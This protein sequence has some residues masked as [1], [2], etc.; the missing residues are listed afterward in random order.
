MTS[1]NRLPITG[2]KPKDLV[3]IPWRVAFALQADG[4]Y[5]RSDIIW[6]KPN[7]MPSSVKD[8]PTT[9]HEYVFLLSKSA[10][11]HYDGQA[12]AEP[13][14]ESTLREI[15]EGYNGQATKDYESAGVQDP[16]SVKARIIA[17]KRGKN[18][19][20]GD[21]RKDG[22]NERWDSSTPALTRNRRTV[23][24]IPTQPFKGAHFATFPEALVE[25]CILAGCPEGGTVL[26]PFTGSGTTGVVAL[27]HH[28]R[29]I[30]IEI[31]PAYAAMATRRILAAVPGPSLF[32]NSQATA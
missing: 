19:E 10:R 21:R 23:W 5:L 18:E 15:A 11:Y 12:I 26:D 22:F 32:I 17:G 30:G 9:S 20:T 28:R 31:N 7:P 13:L 2:L 14:A 6:S 29:F 8:R 3:G 25:P 24:T 16:S 4:W 27:R 1:P